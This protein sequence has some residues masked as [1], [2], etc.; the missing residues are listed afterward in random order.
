M[1]RV[2]SEVSTAP[3]ILTFQPAAHPP[4]WVREQV[5]TK[6]GDMW[7][8]YPCL[9]PRVVVVMV[10]VG[11]SSSSSNNNNNNNRN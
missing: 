5:Q 9:G 11:N 2:R 6:V 3:T 7:Y 10:V 4:K 1:V 8:C